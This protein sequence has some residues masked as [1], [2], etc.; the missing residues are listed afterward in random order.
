MHW[1]L[2]MACT[3]SE[4][5]SNWPGESRTPSGWRH[6]GL[7]HDRVD[8]LMP[9]SI[10]DKDRTGRPMARSQSAHE[11]GAKSLPIMLVSGPRW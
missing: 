10:A 11:R 8:R 6:T 3:Q 1:P 4:D 2:S 7:G 9:L 5:V